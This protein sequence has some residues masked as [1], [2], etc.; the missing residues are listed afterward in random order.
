MSVL[1]LV[2]YRCRECVSILRVLLDLAL[3]GRLRGLVVCYTT[4]DG[5]EDTVLTGVYKVNQKRA[6]GAS[7]R[8]GFRLMQSNGEID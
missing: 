2:E 3:A 4:E 8:M 1:K 6:A 7:L 5:K